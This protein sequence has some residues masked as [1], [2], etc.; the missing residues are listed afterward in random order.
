MTPWIPGWIPDFPLPVIRPTQC[1]ARCYLSP[2]PSSE[3]PRGT[4]STGY[5]AEGGP[6]GNPDGN[7]RIDRESKKIPAPMRR[8]AR[9]LALPS[10]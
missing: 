1:F 10:T 2:N 3:V 9:P 4:S 7:P 8:L 5:A 6:T